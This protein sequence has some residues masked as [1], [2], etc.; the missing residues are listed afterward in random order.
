MTE[1][2]YSCNDVLLQ[3]STPV[4]GI[5][6]G[7]RVVQIIIGEQFQSTIPAPSDFTIAWDNGYVTILGG[8]TN[9]HRVFV[10]DIEIEGLYGKERWDAQYVVE[11]NIRRINEDIARSCEQL[12]RMHGLSMWFITDKEYM[13]GGAE[14]Y[15]VNPFFSQIIKEGIG[16]RPYIRFEME[17]F[18]TGADYGTYNEFY[19]DVLQAGVII[20]PTAGEVSYPGVDKIVYP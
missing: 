10:G 6:Y 13:F 12:T 5:D 3:P 11:G 15:T 19:L 9:G 16:N 2:V 20:Y 7:E 18:A 14:G 17:Y 8:I 1:L 4:C